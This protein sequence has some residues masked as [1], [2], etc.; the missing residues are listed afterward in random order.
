MARVSLGSG[1]C[2]E[3]SERGFCD[4]R[5][6]GFVQKPCL[7]KAQEVAAIAGG[8][9][10][11]AHECDVRPGKAR[12]HARAKCPIRFGGKDWYEGKYAE[13]AEAMSAAAVQAGGEATYKRKARRR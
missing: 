8:A 2:F 12:C 13:E 1:S 9:T 6:E 3:P 4:L 7:A 11:L 5:N 10:G